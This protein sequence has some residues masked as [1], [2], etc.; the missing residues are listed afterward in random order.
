MIKIDELLKLNEELLKEIELEEIKEN[1]IMN[2][3]IESKYI[4]S[5][6]KTFELF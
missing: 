6:I 1:E 3:R 5:Y 2:K 4:I